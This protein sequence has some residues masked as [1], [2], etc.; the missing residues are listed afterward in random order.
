[1]QIKGSPPSDALDGNRVL[2]DFQHPPSTSV[3][4]AD[5]VVQCGSID[6][7]STAVEKAC[8]SFDSSIYKHPYSKGGNSM[9]KLSERFAGVGYIR[10]CI[11]TTIF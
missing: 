8:T 3:A 9:T 1:M 4:D 10:K 5:A 7:N 11:K 6:V 2:L